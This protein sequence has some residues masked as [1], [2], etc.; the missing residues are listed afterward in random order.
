MAPAP[1]GPRL[2]ESRQTPYPRGVK[3]YRLSVCKGPDCR[4]GGADKVFAAAR[5][6]VQRLN[7]GGRCEVYRGGCYGL[8]HLGPNVVV[9]EDLGQPRDLLGGDEF[10]LLRNEGEAYY[11]AM[12]SEKVVRV[13]SEHVGQERAAADLIGDPEKEADFRVAAPKP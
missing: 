11:W 10:K 13:V 8:C 5:E 3:R 7:L 2:P 1:R 6:E 12:S 9:R 4:R